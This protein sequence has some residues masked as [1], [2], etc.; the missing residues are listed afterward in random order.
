M[1]TFASRVLAFQTGL[2]LLAC[3]AL[4]ASSVQA[5]SARGPGNRGGSARSE[6]NLDMAVER[7]RQGGTRVLSAE[8][9]SADGRRVHVIKVLTKDGRVRR[10]T[11]DAETGD[12]PSRGS[13]PARR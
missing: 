7:A 2:V 11:V 12:P 9:V 5:Q 10:L 8:T 4:A 3:L 13:P 6:V 1:P